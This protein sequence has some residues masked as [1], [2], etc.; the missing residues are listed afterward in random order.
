LKGKYRNKVPH[1][2]I[3]GK[4]FCVADKIKIPSEPT[5]SAPV[6]LNTNVQNYGT[7]LRS[8]FTAKYTAPMFFLVLDYV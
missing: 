2:F 5:L 6:F 1:T 8:I 4:F 7:A 3:D